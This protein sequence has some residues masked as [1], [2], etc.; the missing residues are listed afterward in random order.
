MRGLKR[1]TGGG[2]GRDGSKTSSASMHQTDMPIHELTIEMSGD[3]PIDMP[4][5]KRLSRVLLSIIS[6]IDP[7]D[8]KQLINESARTISIA[9]SFHLRD[10]TRLFAYSNSEL[11]NHITTNIDKICHEYFH[12]SL[13]RIP[14]QT[15]IFHSSPELAQV[16]ELISVLPIYPYFHGPYLCIFLNSN[17]ISRLLRGVMAID[18]LTSENNINCQTGGG[19]GS[20]TSGDIAIVRRKPGPG[21]GCK[22][23]QDQFTS[24]RDK[25]YAFGVKLEQI[26]KTGITD[27]IMTRPSPLNNATDSVASSAVMYHTDATGGNFTP[28]PPPPG[29]WLDRDNHQTLVAA[30]SGGDNGRNTDAFL[31]AQLGVDIN[32]DTLSNFTRDHR[33]FD[34]SSDTLVN[35]VV[36]PNQLYNNLDVHDGASF[37]ISNIINGHGNVNFPAY[38]P[39]IS[40]QH[41]VE[42]RDP[43]TAVPLGPDGYKIFDQNIFRIRALLNDPTNSDNLLTIL[44]LSTILQ[45]GLS[46]LYVN[47]FDS[48]YDP[49]SAGNITDTV[50]S[51]CPS[52]SLPRN[53]LVPTLQLYFYHNKNKHRSAIGGGIGI[54]DTT[55][56]LMVVNPPVIGRRVNFANT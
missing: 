30:A 19:G 8:S 9:S 36:R 40:P 54:V 53:I 42:P 2:S 38:L 37:N 23:G 3:G 33:F 24:Y 41:Q 45:R 56:P 21:D 48:S 22:F 10:W 31:L 17:L 6:A 26:V 50:E 47:N 52:P 15:L 49:S 14:E 16:T 12:R 1:E 25:K 39:K 51:S 32:D 5:Y 20:D 13:S 46:E 4:S 28:P 34:S 44:T 11:L 27:G 18:F 55:K 29:D 7:N 43:I 35:R